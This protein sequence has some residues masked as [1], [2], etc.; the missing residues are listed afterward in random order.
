M[1]AYIW[2]NPRFDL[3]GIGYEVNTMPKHIMIG[4]LACNPQEYLTS[5][6]MSR[7]KKDWLKVDWHYI[8]EY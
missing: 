7:T 5:W 2:Y 8:G 6:G 4:I 1:K 3:I